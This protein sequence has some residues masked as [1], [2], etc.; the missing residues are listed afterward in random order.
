MRKLRRVG[1]PQEIEGIAVAK[2]V[3]LDKGR[4]DELL[5]IYPDKSMSL[6]IRDLMD[7]EL[8]RV[9]QQKNERRSENPIKVSYEDRGESR[10]TS[11]LEFLQANPGAIEGIQDQSELSQLKSIMAA[12]ARRIDSHSMALRSRQPS[13]V[14]FDLVQNEKD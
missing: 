10:Q 13:K 8:E 1:R 2:Q 6:I 12:M 5:E 7:E 3:I 9:N 4:L 14:M 11:L